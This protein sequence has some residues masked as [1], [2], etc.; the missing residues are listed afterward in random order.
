MCRTHNVRSV[1]QTKQ[2]HKQTKR[3]FT[4]QTHKQTTQTHNKFNLSDSKYKET[5]LRDNTQRFV[6]EKKKEQ[7]NVIQ[8]QSTHKNMYS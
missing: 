6:S 2:T 3:Q 1:S 7:R 4:E 5:G 8:R